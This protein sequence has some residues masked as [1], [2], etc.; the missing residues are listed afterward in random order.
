MTPVSV[1]FVAAC[2][3]CGCSLGWH[4]YNLEYPPMISS[5]KNGNKEDDYTLGVLVERSI[6]KVVTVNTRKKVICSKLDCFGRGKINEA[7]GLKI[8]ISSFVMLNLKV[9]TE[10]SGCMNN[11]RDSCVLAQKVKLFGTELDL[12]A[13]ILVKTA[14][15]FAISRLNNKWFNLDNLQGST[16]ARGFSTLKEAYRGRVN[17]ENNDEYLSLN[18]KSLD[19]SKGAFYYAIFKKTN[20]E[21]NEEST[22][23]EIKNRKIAPK[24]R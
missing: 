7:E 21:D 20:V 19:Y 13:C 10:D 9:E 1:E 6:S 12:T 4:S 15:L 18:S 3:S 22:Q 23:I 2:D 16:K 11:F 17:V 14:H 8:L 5:P 24:L